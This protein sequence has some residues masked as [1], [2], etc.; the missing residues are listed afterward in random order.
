M[1]EVE[2]PKTNTWSPLRTREVQPSP[3][4][5]QPLTLFN[6]PHD[7][8]PP[9]G[10]TEL[11]ASFRPSPQELAWA[12]ISEP[13]P[14]RSTHLKT[15]PALDRV[16]APSTGPSTKGY[17]YEERMRQEEGDI[18]AVKLAL[19][20]RLHRPAPPPYGLG[21][22]QGVGRHAPGETTS[23][24]LKK[25]CAA[26]A[27]ELKAQYARVK[28]MAK[29]QQ[30][31]PLNN[32]QKQNRAPGKNE[33]AEVRDK[34]AGSREAYAAALHRNAQVYGVGASE[35]GGGQRL[36]EQMLTIA[37]GSSQHQP[38]GSTAAPRPAT[39]VLP[40]S[41]RALQRQCSLRVLQ[42]HLLGARR[43][44][45][46]RAVLSWE[47]SLRSD[48]ASGLQAAIAITIPA[49]EIP[50]RADRR[51]AFEE[52]LTAELAGVL[53]VPT[54]RV[55]QLRVAESGQPRMVRFR[56]SPGEPAAA[57]L[58]QVLVAQLMDTGSELY[59]GTITSSV[60]RAG[61]LRGLG[62]RTLAQAVSH[63]SKSTAAV[64]TPE[65]L[66]R[67]APRPKTTTTARASGA[68]ELTPLRGALQAASSI[69][70]EEYRRL[71]A[72]ICGLRAVARI[73]QTWNKLEASQSLAQWLR[74]MAACQSRDRE[75]ALREVIA[76][77]SVREAELE[78]LR[79]DEAVRV[80]VLR[81]E[82]GLVQAQ[83]AE[84]TDELQKAQLAE[85]EKLEVKSELKSVSA[86]GAELV[87]DCTA[88]LSQIMTA[89]QSQGVVF[90]A[91]EE[92]A[93]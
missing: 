15:R 60:D 17:D 91:T 4:R 24:Q 31:S 88:Q 75:S 5:A 10:A 66:V 30:S 53:S 86:S 2:V 21:T 16:V 7:S 27:E 18:D 64:L 11:S 72:V 20:S 78:Q 83:L 25:P 47:G 26:Q 54:A 82:M 41:Q 74:A 85:I 42:S 8:S 12:A 84:R 93:K 73:L 61:S 79:E 9:L 80:Q 90:N 45:C 23:S 43:L 34:L 58:K 40:A 81:R 39:S 32:L 36:H 59:A 70:A 89:L 46:L 57:E 76:S 56:I 50:T 71:T 63:K 87:A 28:Q 3:P 44:S 49:N 65:Q 52:L 6:E 51:R 14:Y 37:S 67:S 33:R 38:Q 13:G 62:E 19:D 77:G 29:S 69:A 1:P 22:T 48:I 35:A 68:P 92:A 55:K